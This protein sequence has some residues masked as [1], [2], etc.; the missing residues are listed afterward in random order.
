MCGHTYSCILLKE[1][2]EMTDAHEQEKAQLSQTLMQQGE[3]EQ[4][5]EALK[6]LEKRQHEQISN[7]QAELNSEL[8]SMKV[9]VKEAVNEET[10]KA[11]IAAHKDI[12]KEVRMVYEMMT[13]VSY[14]VTSYTYKNFCIIHILCLNCLVSLFPA[15]S[16]LSRSG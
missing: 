5:E 6:A 10:N 11:V 4:L 2:D 14:Y 3:P 8:Q 1:L 13:L 9:K 7:K 15:G 16:E 12:L